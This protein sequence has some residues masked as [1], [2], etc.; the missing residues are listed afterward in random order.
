MKNIPNIQYITP[1]AL[2][3]YLEHEGWNM[4]YALK[5][6]LG[7]Q[8]LSPDSKMGVI[9]PIKVDISDY[10]T[11]VLNV[12]DS[13]A[14]YYDCPASSLIVKLSSPLSDIL[15]WRIHNIKTRY[16]TLPL[17][18]ASVLIEAIKTFISTSIRDVKNPEK[19]HKRVTN[20]VIDDYCLGQSERG[21]Y[22]LNILCPLSSMDLELFE[23]PIARQANEHLLKNLFSIQHDLSQN[24]SGKVEENIYNGV[25]SSNFVDAIARISE[26]IDK[27]SDINL[28]VDWCREL[29]LNRDLRIPSETIIEVKYTDTIRTIADKFTKEE[30]EEQ[31]FV[32]KVCELKA[33]PDI[34]LRENGFV[35]IT[36]LDEDQKICKINIKLNKEDLQKATEAFES[37][38]NI[39][40]TGKLIKGGR[41]KTLEATSFEILK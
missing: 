33:A 4:D 25:Y 22:V 5:N 36:S 10:Y 31:R 41:D 26:A 19:R 7:I 11:S 28:S 13:L 34:G 2:K 20:N 15:K 16:G 21:S 17:E 3:N 27:I 14:T 18:Q 30:I 35:K 12:I 9:L 6:G 29:P 39:I 24:N 23:A 1:N 8:Y 40:T 32:G 37:G 38:L